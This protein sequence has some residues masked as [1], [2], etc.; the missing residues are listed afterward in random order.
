MSAQTLP[1]PFNFV[2]GAANAATV[3]A[4]GF[5]SIKKMKAVGGSGSGGGPSI[6]SV[7]LSGLAASQAPVQ[8]TTQVTG[9]STEA[10]MVD[11]RVYVVESDITNTQRKV[12]TA[13]AEATF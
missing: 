8:A 2:V 4:T 3:L 12:S 9:A 5:A 11:T 13:E 7:S 6:P 10:A 1:T